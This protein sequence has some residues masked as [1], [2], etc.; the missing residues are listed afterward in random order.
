MIL[1]IPKY[2]GIGIYKI[3]NTV[4]GRVYIGSALNCNARLKQ[5]SKYPQ[6]KKMETDARLGDFTAEILKEFPDGCTNAELAQTE[7]FYIEHYKSTM[8]KGYND[9]TH[10]SYCHNYRRGGYTDFVIPLTVPKGCKAKIKAHA[11][12]Q[13]EST[14]AFINRA[15]DET[16]QRDNDK[17]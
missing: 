15:I 17:V 7:Q 9:K 12:A 14:N 11:E 6:N 5:H 4:T 1:N 3:T 2:D 8:S 10:S 16:M 13:G